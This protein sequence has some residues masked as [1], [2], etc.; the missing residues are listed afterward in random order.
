MYCRHWLGAVHPSLE[1]VWIPLLPKWNQSLTSH[2]SGSIWTLRI[3]FEGTLGHDDRKFP[4]TNGCI[5][6]PL[7]KGSAHESAQ[8]DRVVKDWLQVAAWAFWG[9]AGS[10]R[11]GSGFSQG[12][13]GTERMTL[14]K[15]WQKSFAG[16]TVHTTQYTA[17]L[18]R[19]LCQQVTRKV[20]RES[21]QWSE[22]NG[23]ILLK[24]TLQTYSCF[25]ASFQACRNYSVC[26]CFLFE[27]EV[28]GDQ[29]RCLFQLVEKFVI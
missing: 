20:R 27:L 29:N 21:C 24:W 4:G 26:G 14:Q 5:C 13:W 8:T 19:V 2:A 25:P 28:S 9:A 22:I 10:T 12:R 18:C 7:A 17:V 6:M 16:N 11:C 1:A 15:C 23:D 3:G